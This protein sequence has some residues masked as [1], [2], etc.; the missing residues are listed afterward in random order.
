MKADIIKLT[1]VLNNPTIHFICI[2]KVNHKK[3]FE[4]KKKEIISDA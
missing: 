3:A 2:L 1:K 4:K